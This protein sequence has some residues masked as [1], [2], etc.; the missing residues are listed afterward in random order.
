MVDHLSGPTFYWVNS[1]CIKKYVQC[2]YFINIVLQ[3]NILLLLRWDS[4]K[5][6]D[7]FGGMGWFKGELSCKG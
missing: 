4:G 1:T 6:S 5:V 3:K 7:W 2:T